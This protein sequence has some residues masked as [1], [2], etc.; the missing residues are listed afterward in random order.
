MAIR[1]ACE[2]LRR[3]ELRDASLYSTL[4]P[5]GMCTMASI[6]TRIGRVIYGA[7]RADVHGMYFEDR[8]LDTMDFLKD[9]YRD[10]EVIEGVM[11]R[12]C[13]A[14]Y[15]GPGDYPPMEEQGNI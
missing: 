4:Q 5:C 2:A 9:T 10:I 7:G 11:R 6:W 12:E 13:A 8:H 3:D 15:W 14:L 1:R